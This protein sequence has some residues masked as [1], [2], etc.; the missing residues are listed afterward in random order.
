[1]HRAGAFADEHRKN[2]I[3]GGI[4]AGANHRLDLRQLG[5]LHRLSPAL[6]TGNCGLSN[7]EK[8][9]G[10]LLLHVVE[11]TPASEGEPERER[12]GN[13]SHR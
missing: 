13:R 1:M 2:A 7:A 11:K 6:P 12:R 8:F 5:R 4:K 9:R 3:S 10:M